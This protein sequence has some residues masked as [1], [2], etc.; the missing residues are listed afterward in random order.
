MLIGK[1][2]A[3]LGVSADDVVCRIVRTE[4]DA[5]ASG[6]QGTFVAVNTMV[7]Q[8]LAAPARGVPRRRV[9]TYVASSGPGPVLGR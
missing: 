9:T 1:G 5:E 4:V 3:P 6:C 2:L 7:S 8:S